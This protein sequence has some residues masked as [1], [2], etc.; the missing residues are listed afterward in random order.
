MGRGWENFE[1]DDGKTLDC[2]QQWVSRNTDVNN[3]PS[4]DSEGSEQC[5]REQIYYLKEYLHCQKQ[6]V[7]RNINMKGTAREGA[8]EMRSMLLETGEKKSLSYNYR[9]LSGVVP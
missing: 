1:E 7:S 4:E 5:G 6:A 3:S 2:L 9:K 8:D